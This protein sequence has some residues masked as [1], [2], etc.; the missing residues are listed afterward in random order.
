[1]CVFVCMYANN[2]T[3]EQHGVMS[4]NFDETRGS[5]G[6]FVVCKGGDVSPISDVVEG[7]S[8]KSEK[9]AQVLSKFNI[10]AERCELWRLT[11]LYGKLSF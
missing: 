8:R 7:I 11:F 2:V 4:S 9:L 3:S 5:W 1:M 10:F 6:A